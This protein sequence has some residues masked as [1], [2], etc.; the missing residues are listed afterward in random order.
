MYTLDTSPSSGPLYLV[1]VDDI[2]NP[3]DPGIQ[4]VIVNPN[5]FLAAWSV[6]QGGILAQNRSA[7]IGTVRGFK[8][9]LSNTTYHDTGLEEDSTAGNTTASA[10]TS[11]PLTSQRAASVQQQSVSVG[12]TV[13]GDVAEIRRRVES[14]SPTVTLT[15]DSDQQS[16]IAVDWFESLRNDLSEKSTGALMYFLWFSYLQAL[17]MVEY[18]KDNITSSNLGPEDPGRPGLHYYAT[19]HVWMY[20]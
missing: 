12:A 18:S 2:P 14:A 8:A 11:T 10:T 6:D 9:V 19:V 15:P 17:S 16:E 3:Q 13:T 4:T 1:Q 20:G 7:A 5:W